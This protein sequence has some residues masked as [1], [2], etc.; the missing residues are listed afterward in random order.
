MKEGNVYA[1]EFRRAFL[2]QE[3]F[4]EF[5]K[6]IT[7]SALWERR[8]S[9]DLRLVALEEDSKIAKELKEKYA[10]QGMDEGI[11]RIRLPIPACCSRQRGNIIR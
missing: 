1:D 6:G 5:I 2:E 11:L 10:D 4:L 7:R 3:D 8:R 9:K